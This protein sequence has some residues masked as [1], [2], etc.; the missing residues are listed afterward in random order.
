MYSLR[1][2]GQGGFPEEVTFE[3]EGNSSRNRMCKDPETETVLAYL[4][5]SKKASVGSHG[6][7][8]TDR[9]RGDK[10]PWVM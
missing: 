9:L 1:K 5:D 3:W 8:K 4:K 7:N 6:E 10:G 2:G